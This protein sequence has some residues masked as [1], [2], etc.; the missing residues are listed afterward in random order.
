MERR[1]ASQPV[2]PRGAGR[3]AARTASEAPAGGPLFAVEVVGI[4]QQTLSSRSE[5][6][7]VLEEIRALRVKS[8][9]R[10]EAV[11]WRFE[12]QAQMLRRMEVGLGSLGRRFGRGFEEAVRA[13]VEEFAGVGGRRG[14]EPGG[15]S[16]GVFLAAVSECFVNGAAG[17]ER[18]VP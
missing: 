12:L 6:V 16:A 14:A 9:R 11:D 8:C 7:R 10:F 2:E 1:G 4:L 13:T 5:L 18:E 15:G 17:G 3:V